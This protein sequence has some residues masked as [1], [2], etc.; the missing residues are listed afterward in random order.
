MNQTWECELDEKDFD[1]LVAGRKEDWM[2][3]EDVRVYRK[4]KREQVIA[5]G[6]MTSEEQLEQEA[7]VNRKIREQK[8]KLGGRLKR[9]ISDQEYHPTKMK[10]E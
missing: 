9:P 4:G 8:E 10:P 2:I 3:W 5:R 6:E 7:E 1:F